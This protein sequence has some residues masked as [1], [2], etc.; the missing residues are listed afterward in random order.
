M[1]SLPEYL[2]AILAAALLYGLTW[3]NRLI[4]DPVT[5]RTRA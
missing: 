4:R 5:G 3:R 2:L 1:T